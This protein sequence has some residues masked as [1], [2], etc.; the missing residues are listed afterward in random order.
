MP[1]RSVLS[2]SEKESLLAWPTDELERIRFYTLSSKDVA[3]VRERRGEAN[4][5]GFAV[6]LCAMRYP[7]IVLGR[8]RIPPPWLLERLAEQLNLSADWTEYLEHQYTRGQHVLALQSMY[9]FAS[10]NRSYIRDAVET[11]APT[12]FHTDK[13]IIVAQA[14]VDYLRKQRILLPPLA[15]IERLSAQA[16]TQ[17]ERR[18]YA[19]LCQ[20]ITPEQQQKLEGFL[21]V[22]PET[23]MTRLRWLCQP[24]KASNPKQI[25]EHIDR[26]RV[27]SDLDL[28]NEIGYNIPLQR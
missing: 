17:A 13:G 26:L 18:I 11:L 9:G 20:S 4:R 19:L 15:V 7:G 2:A 24:P 14:L 10:F 5:L 1:R 12:A 25:L 16:I 28:P 3:I 21:S 23:K 8:E 27:L 6:Q 22:I